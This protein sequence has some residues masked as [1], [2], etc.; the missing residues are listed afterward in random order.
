MFAL[1]CQVPLVCFGPAPGDVRELNVFQ[2]EN[3]TL[4]L[5]NKLEYIT[6]S[7]IHFELKIPF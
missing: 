2:S 1:I 3:E 6:I 7:P 4:T 5:H